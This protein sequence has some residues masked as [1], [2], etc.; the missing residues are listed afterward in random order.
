MNRLKLAVAMFAVTTV[1]A[2]PTAP[3]AFAAPA[4][5]AA[6]ANLSVSAQAALASSTTAAPLLMIHGFMD[7]CHDAFDYNP[8]GWDTSNS[9]GYGTA[10]S[11]LS[12]LGFTN[13]VQIGYYTSAQP[14]LSVQDYD[15]S[16][17]QGY[18]C[19]YNLQTSSDIKGSATGSNAYNG[20]CNNIDTNTSDYGTT[21]DHIARL[22]CLLAWL[23][24]DHYTLQGQPVNVL[25]HSMGG[26]IIRYA[27]GATNAG[28][29]NFPPQRLL[30]ANVVTVATPHQ[31]LP[32]N[33]TPAS[34]YEAAVILDGNSNELSDMDASSG[35]MSTLGGS[36]YQ[37]P[38]GL[39]G[40]YWTLMGAS[41]GPYG[42]APF[43]DAPPPSGAITDGGNIISCWLGDG[44]S[45]V[46]DHSQMGMQSNAKILYGVQ[47]GQIISCSPTCVYTL[48]TADAA[49]QY[50]HE[51][52][53]PCGSFLG[54]TAC[55][56]AG[57]YY[58]ND[59]G[60]GGTK[61]WECHNC[62]AGIP[63]GNPVNESRS[64]T[65]TSA[66]LQHNSAL[67]V[68][69]R[70]SDGSTDQ[71]ILNAYNANGGVGNLGCPF[72]NGGG[73]YVHY[74]SGPQANVQDFN[75][76][77][78]GPAV[79]VDGPQGSYFVNYGFRTAYVGGGYAKTCLAPVNNAYSYAG[80]TRQD[81]VNCYMT[82]T[83][84]GGVVVHG[85]NPTTCTD[86]GG[87][88][89]TGPNGC[90]GFHTAPP[91][92]KPASGN[93]W[94]SGKGVGFKGQEIWT[95]AN[96]TVATSTAVYNL[97]GL[98]TATASQLQAYIPNNYS[99]A[100]HAHYHYCSPGGGCADGYVNQNNF[101][102]AW[103]TFGAVCTTDGTA[104]IT[105]AD[106]GG[107]TYPAIVGADA[108][109]AVHTGIAC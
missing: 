85:P 106:D 74:W 17:A 102:N 51:V 70:F 3:A 22:G 49:T 14:G 101:T 95:Y 100:S 86:Y 5:V 21:N 28:V 38:Q 62:G 90:V 93:V 45:V 66:G 43:C 77:S 47:L 13:Q 18:K 76:G 54:V 15:T 20:Q 84:A 41:D 58:L 42:S 53:I 46:P 32:D 40:T 36:A 87:S 97:S 94:F 7:S 67:C 80:G 6:T 88:T 2:L 103:A 92:G 26:L 99:D 55:F 75:G 72:D 9:G 82:W 4:Q 35:L 44:D 16:G 52:T 61:A 19:D 60:S 8:S 11:F 57:P 37:Q 31:G 108:I 27:I 107:D 104:T 73:V 96:G 78:F 81:F 10:S 64:L 105:L 59:T 30:V 56:K 24:F 63:G 50:E 65:A 39:T 98:N 69:G 91:P 25:A 48:N 71:A 79:M 89:M 23:I 68:A 33:G 29:A 83:S 12:G 1:V 34:Y 109:R